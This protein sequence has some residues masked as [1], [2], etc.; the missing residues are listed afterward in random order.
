MLALRTTIAKV[1]A[2]LAATILFDACLK[3]ED[4]PPEPHIDFKSFGVFPNDSASLTI[5]FSDGDGDVGLTDAD[6]QAPYDANLYIE[7]YEFDNGVWTNVDL[8]SAPYI[9]YRV[10]D[11]TPTGQ[12]QTLEGEIA[13]AMEPFSFTHN[14]TADTIKYSVTLLDRALHVSN[15]V[16]TGMIVVP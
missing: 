14:A 15:S 1:A 4:L 3:V 9:A 13:I 5:E 12:N 6:T 7:Y 8:G 11:L 10:P 2:A 16:E